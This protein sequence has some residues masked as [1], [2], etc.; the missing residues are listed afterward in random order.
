MKTTLNIL[1]FIL[2][3]GTLAFAR[4]D[5][6]TII[7]ETYFYC[8]SPKLL[9]YGDNLLV[10]YYNYSGI[11]ILPRFVKS[12]NL[13]EDW[14]D[15]MAIADS[16]FRY[17]LLPNFCRVGDTLHYIF[18]GEYD[19]EGP[20]VLYRQ[21]TDLGNTWGQIRSISN[22]LNWTR[23]ASISHVSNNIVCLF[24]AGVN[25]TPY[26]DTIFIKGVRSVDGGRTWSQ[27]Y[28]I[29]PEVNATYN[30]TLLQCNGRLHLIFGMPGPHALETAYINS[31]D[32]GLTWSD[33]III[34]PIDPFAGQWPQANIDSTGLLAVSWFDYKYGGG[35]GGFYG[36]ILMN[37]STDNGDTWTGEHRITYEQTSLTS[38]V[39]VDNPNIYV[40]YEDIREESR[41]DI[42]FRWSSDVGGSWADEERVTNTEYLKSCSPA[43][44]ISDHEGLKLIHLVWAQE[45]AANGHVA[46][47]YEKEEVPTAISEDPIKSIPTQLSLFA[48]PNPFNS[49]TTI[50]LTGAEQAE[51][52]IYDITGR[53][54]T[55]LYAVGGRA[56]WDASGCSSGLYFARL[57]GEKA[58]TIKLVL[59]K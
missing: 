14:F 18:T 58:T 45:L 24:T 5:N 12:E 10:S 2:C 55:T 39:V 3:I 40:A 47:F 29:W 13:G 1:I 33:P 52:G 37:I 25:N 15:P 54:I 4:W 43:L 19:G 26:D 23:Y 48:Y 51:I 56:L 22:P 27:P 30:M 59:V 17:G 31:D 34:S 50:T 32:E 41:G 42:Y 6:P 28:R 21:S 36:D 49:A 11:P 46:L 7:S 44:A 53:L 8:D 35:G 16:T 38:A 20:H 9:N 57:A